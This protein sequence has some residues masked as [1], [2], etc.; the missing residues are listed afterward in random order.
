VRLQ[1]ICLLA[2]ITL[3]AHATTGGLDYE[4]VFRCEGER[5]FAWYCDDEAL[6]PQP[7]QAN[8][9]QNQSK[10]LEVWEIQTAEE[11]RQ[12]LKRRQDIATMNPSDANMKDY[13]ALWVLSN[14]KASEFAQSWRKVIWQNP[15]YD[16][17]NQAPVNALGI[18][19]KKAAEEET[20]KEQLFSISKH[21]G[22]LFFFR[23]NCPY[24]HKMAPILKR[25]AKTYGF[26]ILP[27]SLDGGDLPD[28]PNPTR[29]RGQ[30]QKLKVQRVPALFMGSKETGEVAPIGFGIMSTEE[31]I[32]RIYVLTSTKEN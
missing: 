2:A 1:L 31:L 28:F 26:E 24:C 30:A 14:E 29:D 16:Y 23:S 22:L 18:Q 10:R 7:V 15:Q 21:H 11:L 19:V 6:P 27:V 17:S 9:Q 8:P 12:E 3:Q 13:L 20:Q 4:S 5:R 25:F 32:K